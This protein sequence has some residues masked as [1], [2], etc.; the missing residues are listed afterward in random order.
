MKL[1]VITDVQVMHHQGQL[2]SPEVEMHQ[3]ACL[4]PYFDEAQIF[5]PLLAPFDVSATALHVCAAEN[6]RVVPVPGCRPR[7][8]YGVALT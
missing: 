5:S 6:M 7:R 3:L 4:C 8:I 1:D 2:V